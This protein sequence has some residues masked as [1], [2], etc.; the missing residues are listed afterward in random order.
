MA[1]QIMVAFGIWTW[2]GP[3]NHVL[4]DDQGKGQFWG[5]SGPLYRKGNIHPP[6]THQRLCYSVADYCLPI[7]P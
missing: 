5:T 4:G 6:F 7:A 2:V 1:E 3:W